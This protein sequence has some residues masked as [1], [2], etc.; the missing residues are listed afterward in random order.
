MVVTTPTSMCVG[1]TRVSTR[2]T[3]APRRVYFSVNPRRRSG[4]QA[5]SDD[6]GNG[7]NDDSASWEALQ[8]V[9]LLVFDLDTPRE[10]IFTTSARSSD[11]ATNAFVVFESMEEA[12]RCA[13]RVSEVARDMP[14]VDSA[15]PAAVRLLCA[16][17]GYEVEFVRAGAGDGFE[18]PEVIMDEGE[19]LDADVDADGALAMSA[20]DLE[21]YLGGRPTSATNN[22]IIEEEEDRA[23]VDEARTVAAR[24]VRDA[25]RAPVTRVRDATRETAGLAR[26]GARVYVGRAKSAVARLLASAANRAAN[27]A[28][29]DNDDA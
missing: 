29:T 5:T 2:S 17:S 14:A 26:A 18:V 13:M 21:V 19:T 3:R 12:L 6:G 15:P 9:Y 8:Q 4:A 22:E 16:A 10:A 11:V 23:R 24:A 20:A 1:A 28:A 27:R 7:V 25:L